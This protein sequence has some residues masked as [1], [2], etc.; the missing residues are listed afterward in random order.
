MQNKTKQNKTK[1]NKTKQ[2]KTPATE[3]ERVIPS[4]QTMSIWMGVLSWDSAKQD[5]G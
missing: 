3:K 2:N 5:Q 4:L 1:Q